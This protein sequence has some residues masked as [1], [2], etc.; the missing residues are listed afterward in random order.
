MGEVAIKGVD[1]YRVTEPV[2][3]G[4]RV[5]LS[6][7]GE[8]YTPEY[9]QGISG[10]A[11]RIAGPCLCAPTC[12]CAM[13]T[14]DLVRLMGYEATAL[15]LSQKEAAEPGRLEAVLK[16]VRAAIQ[17]G[18]P[19][20]VWSAF[21]YYEWDV[22]CGYDPSAKALL[23]RG[24]YEAMSK[25]GAAYARAPETHPIPFL[26]VMS[27]PVIL[28]GKKVG[29]FDARGAEIAALQEAVAHARKQ[30]EK[31]LA[32]GLQ[33]YDRWAAI[34]RGEDEWKPDPA[35]LSY[36]LSI[37][38][39]THRAAS[40]FMLEMAAKHPKA[41]A[42]FR[43]AA[44]HFSQEV[45]FLEDCRSLFPRRSPEEFADPGLRA[46]AANC[47]ARARDEYAKAIDEIAGAL[48]EMASTKSR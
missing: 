10:A 19:A 26:D 16:K 3:E 38:P 36:C 2:F 21:T 7:R 48:P 24:S 29:T 31:G 22:V 39:N 12:S 30:N 40:R 35:G 47:I 45:G 18:R 33:A 9:L 23:G 11:F 44:R 28:V 8:K 43:N 25:P 46:R 5:V 4:V 41:G 14:E 15:D 17:A 37:Y 13:S 32:E 42:R 27:R 20:L 34:F 6:Y 1:R